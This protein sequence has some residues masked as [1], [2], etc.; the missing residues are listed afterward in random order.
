MLKQLVKLFKWLSSLVRCQKVEEK[1]VK[2]VRDLNYAL[3]GRRGK[4]VGNE[5]REKEGKFERELSKLPAERE[6][7]IYLRF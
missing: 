6:P 2:S 4:T 5:K 3:R 7:T 1:P